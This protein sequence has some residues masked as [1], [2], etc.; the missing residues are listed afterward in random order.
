MIYLQWYR[1]Q[2]N[3]QNAADATRATQM[4]DVWPVARLVV[5]SWTDAD[6]A[7]SELL[8]VHRVNATTYLTGE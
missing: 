4:V 3:G 7:W 5:E 2:G 6:R 8:R 1:D